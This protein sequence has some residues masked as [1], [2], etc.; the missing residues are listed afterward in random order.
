[1]TGTPPLYWKANAGRKE[2][3]AGASLKVEKILKG[4]LARRLALSNHLQ[5]L[6]IAD[7]FEIPGFS[8]AGFLVFNTLKDF[9]VFFGHH[10]NAPSSRA[11]REWLRSWPPSRRA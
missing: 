5:H 7:E 6:V 11:C 8:V 2:T 4:Q 9:D 1:M 3:H 10:G